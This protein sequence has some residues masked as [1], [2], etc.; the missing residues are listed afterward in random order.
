MDLVDCDSDW[1]GTLSVF[2]KELR[3]TYN[4]NNV[5]Y[6]HWGFLVKVVTAM[7]ASPTLTTSV[8]GTKSAPREGFSSWPALC[9]ALTCSLS[10]NAWRRAASA[11]PTPS[12]Q[13]SSVTPRS[14]VS[15]VSVYQRVHITFNPI[16]MR[17]KL[18]ICV[19]CLGCNCDENAAD[20]DSFCSV[21]GEVCK[22]IIITLQLLTAHSSQ[23][24][25]VSLYLASWDLVLSSVEVR[26][27]AGLGQC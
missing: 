11:T 14:N 10:V 9:L 7:R 21:R 1:A 3:I 20:P 24:W 4:Y 6:T 27:V 5:N 19:Y 25:S 23:R 12:T 22:V 2:K 8:P 17:T 26:C 18:Y 15:T 16:Y 13:M